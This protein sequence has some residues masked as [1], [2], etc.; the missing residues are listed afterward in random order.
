MKNKLLFLCLYFSLCLCL[1]CLSYAG[2][3]VGNGGFGLI[4][5]ASSEN[6]L[7]G[8]YSLD[9]VLSLSDAASDKDVVFVKNWQES[10]ERIYQL[11]TKKVP[12]LASYFKE[13]SD[14]AFNTTDLT[15]TRLWQPAPFGILRLDDQT[16]STLV[17]KNC[18]VDGETQGIPIVVRQNES[19]S[20]TQGH[21]VYK[22]IPEVVK[23]LNQTGGLQLSFLLV[24]E[25]LWDISSNLERNRRIN[26]FLHSP[27]FE[28]MSP[29]QVEDSLKAMGL[30]IPGVAP[31]VFSETSCQGHQL[32]QQE[33]LSRH[34]GPQI[35][36]QLGMAGFHSRE[37][38]IECPSSKKDCS[39]LWKDNIAFSYINVLPLSVMVEWE[40]G[41]NSEPI[42]FNELVYSPP[43]LAKI[44]CRFVESDKFNLECTF[45]DDNY[46][47]DMTCGRSDKLPTGVGQ[48]VYG[49]MTDECLR[50]EYRFLG[51]PSKYSSDY[52]TFEIQNVLF[53]HFTW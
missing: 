23:S 43:Y 47:R 26:R 16:I 31:A 46:A 4:C 51:R 22:F 8:T 33:V 7:N 17:P 15:A 2:G 52:G 49:V 36:R 21:I 19:F 18:Q 29:K 53:A 50:I 20:G 25:W 41:H 38:Q 1:P 42:G 9:Y 32:S 40:N 39:H 44:L 10:S 14:A 3:A 35:H 27:Q 5:R 13:F 6:F 11:L 12:S 28:S 34:P 37:R 48:K 45:H 24:H 30:S